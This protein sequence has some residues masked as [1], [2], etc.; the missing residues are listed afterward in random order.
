MKRVV[1]RIKEKGITEDETKTETRI[2]INIYNKG[3]LVDQTAVVTDRD[4][5][6]VK[7]IIVGKES[8]LV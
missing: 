3:F 1:R 6:D 2:I 7:T 4:I 8:M 5:K